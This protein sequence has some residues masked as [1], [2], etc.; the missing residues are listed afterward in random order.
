MVAPLKTRGLIEVRSLLG[1]VRR[2]HALK[3]ISDRD[4]RFI[5]GRLQEIETRINW[6]RESTSQ[7]VGDEF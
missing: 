4:F 5:E 7:E 2:L 1:R 6:M 3:R